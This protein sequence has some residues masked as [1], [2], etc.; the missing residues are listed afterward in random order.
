MTFSPDVNFPVI[1]VEKGG[2]RLSVFF[3]VSIPAIGFYVKNR[4][5]KYALQG[6]A[7]AGNLYDFINNVSM[8][9]ND[10]AYG[11]PTSF[12]RGVPKWYGCY[13]A[14]TLLVK[15]ITISGEE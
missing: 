11:I 12:Y 14:P 15:D 6:I 4:E 10:L 5:I 8:I 1:N 3:N 2:L 13:S 7:I 9:G